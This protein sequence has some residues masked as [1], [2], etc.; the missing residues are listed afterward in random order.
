MSSRPEHASISAADSASGPPTAGEDLDILGATALPSLYRLFR[1]YGDIYRIYT[2]AFGRHVW[3][4]SDPEAARHVLV[5]N[6]RNYVKG[7]G[8]E[9]VRILL[10][11]GLMASE[12]ERWR[13]QRK[14]V[15][16]AFHRTVLAALFD[17]MRAANERLLQRWLDAADEKRTLDVTHDVSEVTLEIVLRAIF[18]DELEALQSQGTYPFA[19]L[20]QDDQRNLA[21]AYKF[22]QLS[23][24]V[25]ASV[26]RRRAKGRTE[27]DFLS[28]LIDAG[29]PG[30][31]KPMPQRQ[32]LDEIMTLIV[33]GHETTASAL[34]WMWYCLACNPAAEARLHEE[35]RRLPDR[36][37]EHAN[38]PALAY[39][40]Q[41]VQET[42]RLYPP[43]WLLTRRAIGPD[44]IGGCQLPEGTDVLISPFIVHRHPGFWGD[45]ERFY[46]ERFAEETFGRDQRAAYFPF[47]MGPR[48]CI[49]EQMAMMEMLVHL[50]TIARRGRLRRAS[51]E[52][53]ETHAQVNLRM[54]R[55]LTMTF[56]KWPVH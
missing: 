21:F 1:R 12:G 35:L 50:A 30:S 13:R 15:Q 24:L 48:A 19:I 54:R 8:I 25:L 22:R 41:V 18:G 49:G 28:F 5:V 4:V 6:H 53:V 20:T 44:Q 36:G 11:N 3:L 16:P 34:S 55:P 40:R 37:V 51:D 14:M 27:Q 42:L 56:E 26:E 10:G 45:P 9:R 52:P 23:N 7:I 46:P 33:A 17:G 31:G 29:D 2:P 32:L 43:G 38:L 39:S 47:G